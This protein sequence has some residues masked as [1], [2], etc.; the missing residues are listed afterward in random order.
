MN[1]VLPII[2]VVLAFAVVARAQQCGIEM[3]VLKSNG[4]GERSLPTTIA[5][6]RLGVESEGKTAKEAQTKNAAASDKLTA[7]LKTQNV[8][9]LQTT[10]VSLQPQFNFNVTPRQITGYRASN[11]VSFEVPVARAGTILDGAVTNG[12]TNING[13]SFKATPEATAAARKLAL[14]D[15]VA[16]AKMEASAAAAAASRRLGAASVISIVDSFS[17]GPVSA[18]ANFGVESASARSADAPTTQVIARDQI[19]RA[20]VAITYKLL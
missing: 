15:A 18:R 9:K 17:P 11:T 13:V 12:A 3:N 16:N 7:Y 14:A 10:G 4:V 20:R 6:V 19:I 2:S 5:V 8:Q 1:T